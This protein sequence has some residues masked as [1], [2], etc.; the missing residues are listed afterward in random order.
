LSRRLALVRHTS[1]ARVRLKLTPIPSAIGFAFT[2]NAV[3]NT[4][5]WRIVETTYN[6]PDRSNY[7]WEDDN[8]TLH[9]AYVGDGR[10]F[11]A[12]GGPGFMNFARDRW[13]DALQFYHAGYE[14]AGGE[15][16]HLS[17]RW[18]RCRVE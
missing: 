1:K 4:R 3:P 9:S 8:S 6:G 11:V 15:D 13:S 2:V 14:Y 16:E 17:V 18:G 7:Q 10:A 12:E 5:Q